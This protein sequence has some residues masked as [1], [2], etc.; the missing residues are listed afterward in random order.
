M[1]RK[2]IC[3]AQVSSRITDSQYVAEVEVLPVTCKQAD[4]CRSSLLFLCF[5]GRSSCVAE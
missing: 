2:G 4:F 1:H 5:I 3:V